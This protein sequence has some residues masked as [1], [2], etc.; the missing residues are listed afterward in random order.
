MGF[1]RKSQKNSH[2]YRKKVKEMALKFNSVI[3]GNSSETVTFTEFLQI[4]I[5]CQN[6]SA[7]IFNP[8][9]LQHW[10]PYYKTC[11]PCSTEYDYIGKLDS[12][13]DDLEVCN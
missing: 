7:R 2:K 5:L 13:S 3:N 6:E 10:T 4:V 9:F 1:F 8:G 11:L 12:G